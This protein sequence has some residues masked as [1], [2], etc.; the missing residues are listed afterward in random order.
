MA[1]LWQWRLLMVAPLIAAT[2]ANRNALADI[3]AASSGE[4]QANERKMFDSAVKVALVA[5]P[6]VQA[7]WGLSFPVKQT[8]R[9][10]LQALI[11]TINAG[12]TAI[13]RIHWYLLK[14]VDNA[15]ELISSSRN[16]AYVTS[17][18]GQIFTIADVTTDLGIVLMQ[19]VQ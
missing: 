17:R 11:T 6:L 5:T 7:G 12:Q 14:N 8:M 2:L 15:G 4:T 18:I 1:T 3:I 19:E 9:D 13:N 10:D 16:S